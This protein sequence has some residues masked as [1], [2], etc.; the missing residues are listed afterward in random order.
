MFLLKGKPPVT[1][2]FSLSGILRHIVGIETS[3]V[4]TYR[5]WTI[6]IRRK[7]FRRRL[8]IILKPGGPIRVNA[9]NLTPIRSILEFLETRRTWVETHLAR[10]DEQERALPPRKLLEGSKYPFLGQ[11]Y[12]LKA[13]PTPLNEVFVSLTET[14]ILLHLPN[15][16]YNE[17]GQDLSFGRPALRKFYERAGEALLRERVAFWASQTSLR[18]SRVKI[19]ETKSRWGSCSLDRVIALNWRLIIYR[20]EII[21]SVVVHELCHLKH[22]NHSK[23]FWDLATAILPESPALTKEIRG[24]YRLGEFLDR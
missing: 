13:V 9:A 6:E 5:D 11:N 17:R 1:K 19:K 20:P 18:P 3:E 22:M 12:V 24:Q 21:D 8:S 2:R 15:I 16:L 14:Q 23:A 7:S 10:Y 4:L